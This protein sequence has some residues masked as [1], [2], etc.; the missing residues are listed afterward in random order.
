[1]KSIINCKAVLNVSKVSK[2]HLIPLSFSA[3][4]LH[5]RKMHKHTHCVRLYVLDNVRGHCDLEM[6][7]KLCK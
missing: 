3:L 6:F 1:M 4:Q 5:R 7:L 2:S